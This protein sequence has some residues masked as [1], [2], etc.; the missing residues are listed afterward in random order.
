MQFRI[1]QTQQF[2]WPTPHA[3][4]APLQ[5]YQLTV[6]DFETTL[7]DFL[8]VTDPHADRYT[9][10]LAT[11]LVQHLASRLQRPGTRALARPRSAVKYSPRLDHHADLVLSRDGGGGSVFIEVEFRPNFEKDL[12]KFRIGHN[13]GRLRLGVLIVAVSR[14]NIRGSY[15]SMPEFA[16]VVSV[17][18]EYKPDHPV[19]VIGID[20]RH[21]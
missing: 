15:T 7:N 18:G 19:L 1:I 11:N 5:D 10:R 8:D 21:M 13:S 2:S 9:E 4:I 17:L 14:R 6:S 20:G 16:S 3:V 12:V